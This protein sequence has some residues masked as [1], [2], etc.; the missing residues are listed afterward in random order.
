MNF[1]NGPSKEAPKVILTREQFNK[2]RL[3]PVSEMDPLAVRAFQAEIG[4]LGLGIGR[5]IVSIE[6]DGE[7]INIDT[8]L[9]DFGTV[10]SGPGAEVIPSGF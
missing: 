5:G 4:P 6:V 8:S 10:V 7:E 3:T 2:I 9:Q 1:E